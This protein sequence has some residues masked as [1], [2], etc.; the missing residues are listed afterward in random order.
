MASVHFCSI[1]VSLVSDALYISH[2]FWFV[3]PLD[4]TNHKCY[5]DIVNV[6]KEKDTTM[7]EEYE[8]KKFYSSA[9]EKWWNEYRLQKKTLII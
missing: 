6:T 2:V 1:V 7:W 5:I 8:E 9:F 4:I 3:K